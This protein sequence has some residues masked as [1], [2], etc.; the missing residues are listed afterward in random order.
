MV[1][2]PAHG[3]RY[4]VTDAFSCENFHSITESATFRVN[5]HLIFTAVNALDVMTSRKRAREPI[6]EG[7]L[8]ILEMENTNATSAQ[9][10]VIFFLQFCHS[11]QC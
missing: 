2:V 1:E 7:S 9:N 4:P 8:S 10:G 11:K 3:S 6:T 5:H